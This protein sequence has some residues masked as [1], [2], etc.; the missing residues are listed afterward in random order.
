MSKQGKLLHWLY[1]IGI[2]FKGVD[3]A[4]EVIGGV[5]FFA[6]SK[7]ALNQWVFH[8][9]QHEL[10]EDPTDW[11][12]THLRHAAQ[13]LSSNTKV[14]ASA[15]LLGHGAIKCFLVWGGLIRCRPWAFP[16]A[17]VF[18]SAF[19]AYQAVRIIH[20]FSLG[21]LIFTALDL[22]VILLIW[23]EYRFVNINGA[24]RYR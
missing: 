12:S 5:L 10:V 2:W 6:V 17:I 14:F 19:V 3:G 18:L 15:Y 4:L 9:T 22:F 23:R 20:H 11:L 8:L 13:H 16:T 7:A 21:L 24:R 1:E